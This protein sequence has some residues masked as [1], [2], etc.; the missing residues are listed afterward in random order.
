[1]TELQQFKAMLSRAGIGHGIR[2]DYPGESVQVEHP[3]EDSETEFTV[4]DWG[5]NEAGR[6]LNVSIYPGEAG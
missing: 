2:Y 5:F 1:M 3:H 6:L 4:T